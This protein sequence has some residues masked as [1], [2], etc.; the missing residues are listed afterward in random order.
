MRLMTKP[1]YALFLPAAD[2]W[3]R[4]VE[5]PRSTRGEC[6]GHRSGSGDGRLL[7]ANYFVTS[8]AHPIGVGFDGGANAPSR[9]PGAIL[10]QMPRISS[11]DAS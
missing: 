1:P 7:P 2:E 8:G 4:L 9:P 11:R 10:R 6:H 3:L 5:D